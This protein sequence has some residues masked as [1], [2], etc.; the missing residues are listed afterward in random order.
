M[1]SE[2]LVSVITVQSAPEAEM[3]RNALKSVGIDCEIGGETQ[4][5]L[6]GVLAI[7]V[8]THAD[9]AL[10]ARKYLRQLRKEKQERKKKRVEARNA[11]KPTDSSE[12]IQELPPP[13][14]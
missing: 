9:D 7:D 4:A 14:N 11:K 13:P 6:A 8:L 1:D 5:G 3:I 2:D 12:A 10:E